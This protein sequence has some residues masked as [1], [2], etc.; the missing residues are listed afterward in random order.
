MLKDNRV[1]PFFANTDMKKQAT[2]QKQF[3]SMVTG[4]PNL[5]EGEDMRKAHD[6]MNIGDK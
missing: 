5:Y 2:R 4:G 1:A 6:K 3:I